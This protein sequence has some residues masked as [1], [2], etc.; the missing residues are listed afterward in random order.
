MNSGSTIHIKISRYISSDE[1][2]I[3]LTKKKKKIYNLKVK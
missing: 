1:K 2:N 3:I